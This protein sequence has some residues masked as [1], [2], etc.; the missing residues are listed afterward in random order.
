ML[1]WVIAEEVAD[2]AMDIVLAWQSTSAAAAKIREKET[3]PVPETRGVTVN[4][5][6]VSDVIPTADSHVS[7]IMALAA[8]MLRTPASYH[9][10]G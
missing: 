4:Q 5:A 10:I 6:L 9:L 2:W 3:G 8:N 7:A 1:S